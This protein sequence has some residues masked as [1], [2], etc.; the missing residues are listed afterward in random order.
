MKSCDLNSIDSF[1]I[2]GVKI[3]VLTINRLAEEINRWINHQ[4]RDYIV[5]TGVH[6]V[7]EMQKNIEYYG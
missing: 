6:G 5:L 7:I 2:L 4:H 1:T 3:S